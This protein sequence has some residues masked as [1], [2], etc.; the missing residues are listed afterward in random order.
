MG[1]IRIQKLES[2]LL[3]LLNTTIGGKTRDPR[4]EWVTVTKV[5]LS[6]DM[7]Y[8]KVYFTYLEDEEIDPDKMTEILTRSSGFLK[9]E[10]AAAH[11]M[12]VIPQLRFIWDDSWQKAREVERVLRKLRDWHQESGEGEPPDED[13]R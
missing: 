6:T 9:S 5:M 10:I 2:E 12:R 4:L 3:R 8:A 1:T 13:D 7:R 11:M